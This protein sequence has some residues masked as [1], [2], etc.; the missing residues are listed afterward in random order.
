MEL[1]WSG[2][3]KLSTRIK[4]VEQWKRGKSPYPDLYIYTQLIFDKVLKKLNGKG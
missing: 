4:H 3:C 2:Y 1:K